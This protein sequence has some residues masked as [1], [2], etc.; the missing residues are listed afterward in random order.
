MSKP[1]TSRSDAVI[2]YGTLAV[3]YLA[4]SGFGVWLIQREVLGPQAST[5]QEI[6]RWMRFSAGA[7]FFLGV[8]WIAWIRLLSPATHELGWSL[9]LLAIGLFF[10]ASPFE[11]GLP[12]FYSTLS[13][14]LSVPIVLIALGY[15]TFHALGGELSSRFREAAKELG[16]PAVKRRLFRQ[17]SAMGT[18]DGLRVRLAVGEAGAPL[19]E[20]ESPGAPEDLSLERETRNS[21]GQTVFGEQV[22]TGDL[23]FDR[24]VFVR[25]D[26]ATAL[27]A[28]DPGA[29]EVVREAIE[30]TGAVLRGRVFRATLPSGAND[31]RI[32]AAARLLLAAASRLR[33]PENALA[34]L[35]RRAREDSDPLVRVRAVSLLRASFASEGAKAIEAAKD[36][37]DARVR[38]A[39]HGQLAEGGELS[40]SPP[41]DAGALSI[42][43][44]AG[45]L[46]LEKK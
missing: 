22:R 26:E 17:P 9:V 5:L 8:Q 43:G 16:L 35:A 21:F 37:P 40:I 28:L 45:A 20:V 12:L 11:D 19:L 15:G 36:D 14:F 46:T 31:E 38:A 6:A 10:L 2:V 27:G 23:D 4:A 32:V 39:A 1:E 42:A 41:G 25:G 29:R 44:A 24:A 34:G 7:S 3:T 30:E 18:I 13:F 33:A